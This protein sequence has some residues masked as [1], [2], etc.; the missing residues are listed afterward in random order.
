M[1]KGWELEVGCFR[2]GGAP[3]ELWASAL[4]LL[5]HF[6]SLEVLKKLG[7]CCE[8]FLVVDED[9]AMLSHL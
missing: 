2:K 7:D 8:G 1:S 9:T 5:L 6:W 3:K 4:G